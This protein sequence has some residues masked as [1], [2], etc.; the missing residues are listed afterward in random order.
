MDSLSSAIST[1]FKANRMAF[2][3]S[4]AL[5]KLSLAYKR[6]HSTNSN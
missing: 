4:S 1:P 2:Y 6:P 5:S 3:P